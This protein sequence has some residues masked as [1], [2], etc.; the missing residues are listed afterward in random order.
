M[1]KYITDNTG[2]LQVEDLETNLTETYN[3]NDLPQ[4]IITA[5]ILLGLKTKL[6]NKT[7]D[8]SRMSKRWSSLQE[9]I[10]ISKY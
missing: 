8:L 6:A 9:G 4:G 7:T 5:L 10:W 1:L 2:I 3:T